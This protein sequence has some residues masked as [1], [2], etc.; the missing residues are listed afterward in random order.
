MTA[1]TLHFSI[2]AEFVTRIAREWLWDENRPYE[3]CYQLLEACLGGMPEDQK[4][5]TIIAILEGR[6]KLVGINTCE[7]VDDNE[8]VRP[9]SQYIKSIEHARAVEQI[10][11]D[12]D[13][14]FSRYVDHWST[15]KS[16]HRDVLQI[17]YNGENFEPESYSECYRYYTKINGW[18][19]D[20]EIAKPTECGLWLYNEPD[21]VADCCDDDINNAG[22]PEFWENIY[23]R[24]KNRPGFKIRNNKYLASKRTDSGTTEMRKTDK[25]IDRNPEPDQHLLPLGL[26]APNGDYYS[27]SF[28]AH[29]IKA[30]III[31]NHPE[32]FGI[33]PSDKN[34]ESKYDAIY[35]VTDEDRALDFITQ[36][37]WCAIR[38]NRMDGE[39]YVQKESTHRL[40]QKQIDSIFD[41]IVKHD[42]PI[43]MEAVLNDN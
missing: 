20:N 40:T 16:S 30:W 39:F 29:T 28:A 31:Y 2:D 9:L 22:T 3:K 13:I 12:M 24:V 34:E 21:L 35:A 26:I 15:V 8:R 27:C 41:A 1:K 7:V 11:R 23:Q 6:K 42:I 18:F 38:S 19:M 33:T 32:K 17:E 43:N 4:Q 5:P 37:G 25:E 36:K 10:R 14:H